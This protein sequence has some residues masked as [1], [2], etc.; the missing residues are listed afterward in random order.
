MLTMKSVGND[1]AVI[2]NGKTHIF[3]DNT[4]AWTFIFGIM[5]GKKNV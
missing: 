3:F 5:E 4:H 2:Y 1:Y